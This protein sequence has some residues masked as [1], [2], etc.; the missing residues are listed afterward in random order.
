MPTIK[1][2]DLAYIRVRLPD[3]D[4]AEKFLTDFGLLRVYRT[5]DVMYMRG[6]GTSH[7]IHVTERGDEKLLSLAFSVASEADLHAATDIPG[8]SAIEVIGGPGG[9]K[10]VWLRDPDGNGIEIVWGL[11]T[12]EPIPVPYQP[13][14]DA[15]EGLRRAGALSRH[16]RGPSKVLRIG[17]GVF[18]SINPVPM[19]AW[20]REHLGLLCSDEVVM[21]DGTIGL[22][23]HR[24][25]RGNE[26]V[27]H[28]VL[29]IQ[30]GPKA[31]LNH[32]SFE[33]QHV[34]DLMVGHEHLKQQGY[35]AVWGVGRHVYGA[36]IFDYWMDPWGFMYEHWTDTDRLNADS[37][38]LRDAS[39]E[40][41]NGPW[42]MDVPARFF[43]H[44]HA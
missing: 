36:Q 34:D 31:G 7:H 43:A 38:G 44:A 14:N 30:A 32:V 10:R 3:L 9:G 35:D 5:D 19:L 13:L 40:S 8:A 25:D 33:V 16:S 41:A 24:L 42:G 21:P 29:L 28:H 17:H 11:Q 4:H 1:V 12:V 18:M 20:Y 6:T 37:T 39:V 2:H 26:Y 27:D 15:S 22:S 23:F